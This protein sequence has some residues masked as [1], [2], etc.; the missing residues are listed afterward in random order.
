[1]IICNLFCFTA[2]YYLLL[3]LP[4]F[5]IF[6]WN[7]WLSFSLKVQLFLHLSNHHHL[8][9]CVKLLL[10]ETVDQLSSVLSFCW[11]QERSREK[12]R[13]ISKTNSVP[14]MFLKKS[15]KQKAFTESF[16]HVKC[17]SVQGILQKPS[18]DP[19]STKTSWWKQLSFLWKNNQ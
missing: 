3:L 7:F 14:F 2:Y 6:V 9:S 8:I 10:S 15:S 5:G 1:M 17:W 13:K 18:I 19:N 16:V 4:L 11:I 12:N